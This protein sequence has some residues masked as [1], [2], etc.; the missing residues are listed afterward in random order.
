MSASQIL[1]QKGKQK[2]NRTTEQMIPE[3]YHDYLLLFDKKKSK[4][5]PPAKT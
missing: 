1:A 3:E 2:D 5:F 4:R